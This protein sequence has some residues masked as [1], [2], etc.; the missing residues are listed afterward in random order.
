V[1]AVA[2]EFVRATRFDPLHQA[3][4]EQ[5]L[6]DRLPTVLDHLH[7]NSA[8][9]FEMTGG[10]GSYRITVTR[11][12]FIKTGIPL[13]AEIFHILQKLLARRKT[14]VDGVVIQLSHRIARLPGLKKNL[15]AIK[16]ALFIE[17]PAG[18]GAMGALRLW[19]QLAPYEIGQHVSFFT[20]RPWQRSF[21]TDAFTPSDDRR[22]IRQ[23][24][25]I[26]YKNLAY[27][28][29]EKAL[30]IGLDPNPGESGIHI[31]GQRSGV[32]E[33]HCSVELRGGQAFINDLSTDGTFVDDVRVDQTMAVQN[34]QII[35]VGNPGETLQL[36]ACLDTHET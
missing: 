8:V 30:Q 6:F 3:I 4:S 16:D 15:A 36:I 21:Q 32:S 33:I 20:S 1:E 7:R 29:S 19:D 34:G 31:E 24:T 22:K 5:E 26:L 35:R 10:S 25:H 18:A 9:D 13:F 14:P 12:L 17:P 11:E 28:L 27:P 23:P 2:V